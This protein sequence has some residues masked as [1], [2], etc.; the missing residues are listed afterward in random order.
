MEDW[1]MWSTSNTP[2]NSFPTAPANEQAKTL[3]PAARDG[4]TAGKT[5]AQA[6]I[7]RSIV[8]KGEITGAESLQIDGR[9]EGPIELAGN[10][11]QIGPGAVVTS[12]ITAR[13]LVIRGTLQGNTHLDD[14]LDIRTGGSVTGDVTARRISI[15][16]GAYFKG[17][18]DMRRTESKVSPGDTTQPPVEK[19]DVAP[20]LNTSEDVTAGS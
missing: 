14:R 10:Y 13:E 2:S 15:A 8:I 7:G 12:N 16:D 11:V 19:A 17:S 1:P 20:V 9:V 5:Q 3:I 6:V 4:L 18:I